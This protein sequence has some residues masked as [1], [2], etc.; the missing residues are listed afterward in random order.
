MPYHTPLLTKAQKPGEVPLLIL[1]GISFG[2]GTDLGW[3]L[4]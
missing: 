2:M 1:S 3:T 4:L